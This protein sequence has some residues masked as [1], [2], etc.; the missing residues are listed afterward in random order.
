M[1]RAVI[2]KNEKIGRVRQYYY[3]IEAGHPK[4]SI[5][6]YIEGLSKRNVERRFRRSNKLFRRNVRLFGGDV[7]DWPVYITRIHKN[8]RRN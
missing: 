2:K 1:V 8:E 3:R 4:W 7:S 5:T 6:T